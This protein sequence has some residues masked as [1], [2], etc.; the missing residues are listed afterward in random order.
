MFVRKLDPGIEIGRSI[1]I[2]DGDHRLHTAL[3]RASDHLLTIRVELLAVEMCV[4]V[5]K[6]A[7]S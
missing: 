3:T 1:A 2:A 7:C 5:Y 6:H 4:R